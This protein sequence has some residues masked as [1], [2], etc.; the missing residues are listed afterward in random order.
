MRWTIAALTTALLASSAAAQSIAPQPL[1]QAPAVAL[2]PTISIPTAPIQ[3]TV[4]ATVSPDRAT[5]QV[6]GPSLAPVAR[7]IEPTASVGAASQS[8]PATQG[9]AVTGREPPSDQLRQLRR[10]R[11][12]AVEPQPQARVSRPFVERVPVTAYRAPPAQVTP[13]TLGR[14]WPPVF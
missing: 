9:P 7:P 10:A 1:T 2:A 13:R 6:A 4:A 11:A 12:A 3:P 14:F 8:A 5:T